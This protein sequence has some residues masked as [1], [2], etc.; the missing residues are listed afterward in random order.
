MQLSRFTDYALRVLTYL[1]GTRGRVATIDE[2]ARRYRISHEHLRKVVQRLAAAGFV[3]SQRG[4]GGGLRLARAPGEISVGAVVRATEDD[5]AIVECFRPGGSDCRIGGVCRLSGMFAEALDAFL[6]A[7][8]RYTLADI[9]FDPAD[10][11]ARLGL[12]GTEAG[13]GADAGAETR[14]N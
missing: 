4:R 8:D 5:L 9:L 2:I 6:A 11:L 14:R 13:P 7:L 1:G 3:E 12:S 10:L